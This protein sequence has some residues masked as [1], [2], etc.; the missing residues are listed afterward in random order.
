MSSRPSYPPE[1]NVQDLSKK[2]SAGDAFVLLDVRE[3]HELQYAQLPADWVT[4]LPLS[5]LSRELLDGLPESVQS[6]ETE[7]VVMCHTGRR[8]AQV[9]AWLRQNGWTN[10]YNLTGGIEAYAREIDPSVGFY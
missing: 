3:P 4:L 2:L 1:I 6:K 9:T 10:A 7:I 8:S 5:K